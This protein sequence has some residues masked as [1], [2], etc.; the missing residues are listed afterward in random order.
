MKPIRII[1]LMLVA[2]ICNDSVHSE[3]NVW[4]QA[5]T[6]TQFQNNT[7]N[8]SNQS[9]RYELPS[10]PD[11]LSSPYFYYEYAPDFRSARVPLTLSDQELTI[12]FV[13][14][15]SIDVKATLESEDLFFW[16]P[17][18]FKCRNLIPSSEIFRANSNF[19]SL[20]APYDSCLA[21]LPQPLLRSEQPTFTLISELSDEDLQYF[22]EVE[23]TQPWGVYRKFKSSDDEVLKQ[24][25]RLRQNPDIDKVWEMF[26]TPDPVNKMYPLVPTD[27]IVVL[28]RENVSQDQISALNAQYGTEVVKDSNEIFELK[29]NAGG[30]IAA[31]DVA[32]L[33][34]QDSQVLVA[35]P[36][37]DW[38]APAIEYTPTIYEIFLS[39]GRFRID[40]NKNGSPD[41][42][43]FILFAAGFGSRIGE[44]SFDSRF[45]LNDD[46]QITFAD[47]IHFVQIF[48]TPK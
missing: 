36:Y 24:V 2:V 23:P 41:F 35:E 26:Y 21:N 39:E 34:R 12:F 33:F 4:L 1:W 19:D 42:E 31:L 45:D 13:D 32:E 11:S 43:D 5:Q 18:D 16:V 27:K 9:S 37:L 48:S 22:L 10:Y 20:Y 7:R 3:Q 30:G 28:F 15:P 29:I 8:L 47:F 14:K 46:N 38:W 44:M 40:F 17:D 25:K 6:S